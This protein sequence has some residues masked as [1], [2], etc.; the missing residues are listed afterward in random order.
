MSESNGRPLTEGEYR[1]GISF[2]PSANPAVDDIKRR[3]ADLIDTL[4]PIA[5]DRDH[6]GARCASIAMT[7]IESAA[8]WGVK[9]SRSRPAKPFGA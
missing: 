7:E 5:A 1:V 2:N 9:P 3:A 4:A 8:M 6:P